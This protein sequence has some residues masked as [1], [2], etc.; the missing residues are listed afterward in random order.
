[1]AYEVLCG[2]CEQT[3]KR[4]YLHKVPFFQKVDV[5]FL[6]PPFNQAKYY[7]SHDD[8]M[9]EEKYWTWMQRI[10]SQIY[11]LTSEGGAVYFMQREKNAE[12]V[13]CALRKSGWSFQNLIIWKK[14]TSAVP[15]NIRYAKQHQIIAFAT[16]GNRPRVFNKLRID[17]PLSPHHKLER[18]NGVFVTDV[19]DDIREL[20]SGYFSGHEP[21]R[22][23]NGERFHK[24]QSPVELL[25]RIILSSSNPG[26]LV[27][28]P[29]SGTGTTSV[30]AEQL[31][32][33][34][35]AIELDETNAH[36]IKARLLDRRLADNISR[37]VEYYRFTEHLPQIWP[38]NVKVDTRRLQVDLT[39]FIDKKIVADQ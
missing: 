25:V 9:P 34:S 14:M 15:S 1:M 7:A 38:S 17:L 8:E 3:L 12:H 27:I 5:T 22:N 19:W 16:K 29:F 39:N 23:G 36:A 10:L 35:I 11:D 28:D 6:D 32:R 26:D 31:G 21:L 20:T 30:V 18:E 13:L 2:D 24:Q 4:E 33:N 37:L